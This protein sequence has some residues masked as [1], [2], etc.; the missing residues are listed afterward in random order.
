V[1]PHVYQMFPKGPAAG[2]ARAL[3]QVELEPGGHR[4][5]PAA[6]LAGRMPDCDSIRRPGS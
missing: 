2:P 6:R 3:A 1:L 4:Q 5:V